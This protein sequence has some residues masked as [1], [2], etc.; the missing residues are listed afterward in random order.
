M[1]GMTLATSMAL[2]ATA[3]FGEEASKGDA[4][5]RTVAADGH[6]QD[7][8]A[9]QSG[10]TS[11]IDGAVPASRGDVPATGSGSG[12]PEATAAAREEAQRAEAERQF[13]ERIWTGP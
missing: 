5:D 2:F 10:R 7:A 8:G 6:R 4:Y 9:P 1:I 13:V 11:A 12:E 3:A